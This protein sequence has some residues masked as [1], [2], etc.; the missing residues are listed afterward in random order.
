[1]PRL[2]RK[3]FVD[4][5]LGMGGF[6]LLIGVSFPFFVYSLGVSPEQVFTPVFWGATVAAGLLAGSVNFLLARGVVRPR[7]R[8]LA[9][10]MNYVESAI[11]RATYTGDWSG[12][13]AE[14]CRIELDSDDEIGESVRAFNDLVEALFRNHRTNTAVSAFS[15]ALSCEL[16]LE[17]LCGK[18]L[19][20]FLE[21]TGATAGAVLTHRTGELALLAHRGLL[22]PQTLVD[23]GHV[24]RAIQSGRCER[25]ELPEEIR[26]EA[27]LIDFRPR[28]L[29][30]IPAVFDDTVPGLVVLASAHPFPRDTEWL[31]Q[32]F[33]QGLGLALNNALAHAQ[34]Q[35]IA[36]LDPLTNLYN[37]RFGMSRLQEEFERS[38]RFG[39]PLGLLMV[40]VDHF[41][42][43]NDRFGHLT[44]DRVLAQ[45]ATTIRDAVREGDVVVRYGG[46]EFLVVLPGAGRQETLGLAERLRD[47][48]AEATFGDG[49]DVCLQV[50][51]SVGATAYPD[52]GAPN[53][54][55]LIDQAD[56]AVYGAKH[57]GRDRVVV[58]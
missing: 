7:L 54:Q 18:A 24:R 43:L 45:I 52:C 33:R 39:L 11:Q 57:G 27:L 5:A 38:R 58:G 21:H 42:S 2:S 15:T 46:E 55:A 50:T 36:A 51:V 30:L 10:R 37:R 20:L 8:L 12:C 4:L 16:E 23:N 48:V 53:P 49:R 13:T 41:K 34:L 40:D 35:H 22:A 47:Q 9:E 56:R 26:I 14:R 44:G 31:M 17:A 3:L 19:N 28:E 1:M 25:I 29:M 6:G 32:L